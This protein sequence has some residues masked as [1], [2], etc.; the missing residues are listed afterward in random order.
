LFQSLFS[1]RR[2]T[3]KA[4][5]EIFQGVTSRDV[6]QKP[7]ERDRNHGEVTIEGVSALI[8]QIAFRPNDVFM[9]VGSGIGNIVAQVALESCASECV[10][11]EIEHRVVEI[12]RK[13]IYEKAGKYPELSKVYLYRDDFRNLAQF[14]V[15]KLLTT[16]VLFANNVLFDPSTNIK[17][18]EI[19]IN[20]SR[21]RCIITLKSFC[22]R[23]REPCRNRF[24]TL[25]RLKEEVK[26]SVSWTSSKVPAFLY[27][28]AY[29]PKIIFDS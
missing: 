23:H 7:G 21:L 12:A 28:R 8:K 15:P 11:I 19:I 14:V 29:R 13:Q 5:D 4:L 6:R 22:P 24:C 3:Q 16:T 27:V 20:P 10:G 1:E 17:L 26:V 9:D 18:E 25:W 2:P